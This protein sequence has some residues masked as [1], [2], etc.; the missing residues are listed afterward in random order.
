MLGWFIIHFIHT[1]HLLVLVT[2]LLRRIHNSQP[3]SLTV[4]LSIQFRS[5]QVCFAFL[6]QPPLRLRF[7]GGGQL[8]LFSQFLCGMGSGNPLPSHLIPPSP[9]QVSSFYCVFRPFSLSA[10]LAVAAE[11]VV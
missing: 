11:E 5:M 7:S 10:T 9:F 3:V 4:S 6:P 1:S 8:A 2:F